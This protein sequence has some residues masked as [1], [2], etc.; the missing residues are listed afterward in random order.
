MIQPVIIATLNFVA[1]WFLYGRIVKVR[2]TYVKAALVFVHA[3]ITAFFVIYSLNFF[4]P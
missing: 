4:I 1:L 3:A 2:N